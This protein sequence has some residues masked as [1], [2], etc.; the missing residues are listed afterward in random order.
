MPT[1]EY[2]C[3]ECAERFD[4]QQSIKDD[5]L[6]TLPG[7]DHEHQLKKVFHPVGIAFK[8]DGFYKNDA[9]SNSK[10][11]PAPTKAASDTSSSDNSNT[12]S[13]DTSKSDKSSSSSS[14]STST[15]SSSSSSTPSTSSS[16]KSASDSSS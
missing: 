12:S 3:T 14:D 1:Y 5:T 6:T 11:S 4:I 10:S 7:T 16:S 2:K 15:G 9:R 13:S 8:G